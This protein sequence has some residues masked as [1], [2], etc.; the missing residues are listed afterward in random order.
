MKKLFLTCLAA[1]SITAC[2]S[3]AKVERLAI[4][5]AETNAIERA[6]RDVL[7][8]P[9]SA[10]FRNIHQNRISYSDGKSIVRACGEVSAVT[11]GGFQG[12]FRPFV[13]TLK[14]GEYLVNAVAMPDTPHDQRP[15]GR[16][17][18]TE[19][20]FVRGLCYDDVFRN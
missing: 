13:V 11:A 8:H 3:V 17:G 1:V 10:K 14:D 9:E 20:H 4:S 7:V 18:A 16:V 19:A 12:G 5:S 15:S 2:T 6:T